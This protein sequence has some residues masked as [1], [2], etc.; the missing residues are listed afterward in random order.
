MSQP[1]G[2]LTLFQ[3]RRNDQGVIVG[4]PAPPPIRSQC[5]RLGL[6][7]GSSF[8]CIQRLPGGTIIVET[9]RQEIA[10][11]KALAQTIR[12]EIGTRSDTSQPSTDIG[13][14]PENAPQH[15]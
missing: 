10:L 12:V 9:G 2:E 11:G 6:A 13:E 1:D 8:H 3:V 15:T 4:L 14:V 7:L 5:I